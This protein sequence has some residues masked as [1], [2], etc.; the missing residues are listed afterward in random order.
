MCGF[1]NSAVRRVLGASDLVVHGCWVSALSGPELLGVFARG[2]VVERTV[3][4]VSSVY[5]QINQE[6]TLRVSA[7]IAGPSALPLRLS[8]PPRN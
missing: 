6:H 8:C 4:R 3:Q 1:I 2:T 5:R 7:S